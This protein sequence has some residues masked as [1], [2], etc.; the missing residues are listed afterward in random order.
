MHAYATNA[1][2]RD[3]VPIVLAIPA[4]LLAWLTAHALAKIGLKWT[5]W[6]DAPSVLGWYGIL[7]AVYSKWLWK[8]PFRWEIRLSKIPNLNGTWV[9]KIKSSDSSVAGQ[10][11]PIVFHIRQNWSNILIAGHGKNS[12]S[13]SL[14]AALNTDD[15]PDAGLKYEYLNQPRQFAAPT[16]HMNKGTAHLQIAGSDKLEGSYYTGRDRQTFG[17]IKLARVS[18]EFKEPSIVE[19]ALN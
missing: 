15:V 7:F 16:M 9:G 6:L 3:L 13:C 4:F 1:K 11:I 18:K 14:M 12:V 8:K 2:E 17:T 19:P 10:E 5:W